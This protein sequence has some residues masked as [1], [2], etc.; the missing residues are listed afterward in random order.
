MKELLE[1]DN[2]RFG[3]FS[4]IQHLH[5]FDYL[6]AAKFYPGLSVRD[7]VAF[8]EITDNLMRFYFSFIFASLGN[9]IEDRR[10]TV[11]CKKDRKGA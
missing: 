3:R 8:Y 5:D 11:F 4:L 2:P 7:K 9:G 10:R 6:D 1:E